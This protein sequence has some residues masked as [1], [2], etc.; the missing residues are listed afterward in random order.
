MRL[1]AAVAELGSLGDFTRMAHYPDLSVCEY[2][3]AGPGSDCLAVGWL[4]P[5][6]EFARG[7]VSPEFF[8]RLCQLLIEP[9]SFV[10]SAGLHRCGFCRFSGGGSATFKGHHISGVGNGML[11]VPSGSTIYVSPTSIA[12]YIDAHGYCPP[13]EFQRAVRECPEMR[14]LAYMRA[15]LATPVRQ[16]IQKSHATVA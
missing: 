15:L 5:E 13:A 16:W 11:F 3:E 1:V 12:H 9:W 10:A 2:V 4:E 6:R 7:D 8:D 14:S